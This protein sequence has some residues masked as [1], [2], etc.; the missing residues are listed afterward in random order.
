MSEKILSDVTMHI[1]TDLIEQQCETS[2]PR[3]FH[4]LNFPSVRHF[5]LSLSHIPHFIMVIFI[6]AVVAAVV[7]WSEGLILSVFMDSGFLSDVTALQPGKKSENGSHMPTLSGSLSH[8]KPHPACSECHQ[9]KPANSQTEDVGWSFKG[10]LSS[11]AGFV[12]IINMPVKDTPGLFIPCILRRSAV[13]QV[14][15]PEAS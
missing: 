4:N 3:L 13:A 14:C 1:Q 9:T 7:V 12:K 5:L 10:V 11:I 2:G 6:I 15:D 8:R